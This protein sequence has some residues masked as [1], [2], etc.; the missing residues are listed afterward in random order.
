MDKWQREVINFGLRFA[1]DIVK[2][3]RHG[4]APA[5]P[6]LLMVHGGAGAGKSSVIDVLA[7]WAQKILQ[8]EGDDIE[9]PCVILLQFFV[10]NMINVPLLND[11]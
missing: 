1:K 11:N 6:V 8:Q 4:N 5:T 9:C 10:H 3:R 2:G 7:P